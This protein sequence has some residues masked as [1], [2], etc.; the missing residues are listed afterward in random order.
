MHFVRKSSHV[1]KQNIPASTGSSGQQ[2]A[3]RQTRKKHVTLSETQ[4]E[5]FDNEDFVFKAPV[6]FLSGQED[7]S[8][9]FE[10]L[11]ELGFRLQNSDRPLIFNI[12]NMNAGGP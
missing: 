2:V 4:F 3:N 10:S 7:D 11:D 5:E 8:Q 1:E 6:K 12:V 9:Y